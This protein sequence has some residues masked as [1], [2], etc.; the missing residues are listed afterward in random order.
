M[1][2]VRPSLAPH[3]SPTW[4]RRHGLARALVVRTSLAP[5]APIRPQDHL[6]L[7]WMVARHYAR[8]C[9]HSGLE[10]EDLVQEGWFGLCIACER[11]DPGRK[12]KFSTLARWCIR[13]AIVGAIEDQPHP[14]RVPRGVRHAYNRV[15]KGTLDPDTGL[16]AGARD[17]LDAARPF[18]ADPPVQE[19]NAGAGLSFSDLAIDHREPDPATA[20]IDAED[21]LRPPRVPITDDRLRIRDALAALTA[22]ERAV[23]RMECGLDGGESLTHAQVAARLG[24]TRNGCRGIRLRA[25]RR[26]RAMLGVTPP[27]QD[28]QE[29]G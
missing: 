26:L 7:V 3:A 23:I 4:H 20:D 17:C 13:S 2:A 24:F 1:I 19:A 29:G 22:I 25:L 9:P 16:S 21:G 18:L 12:T 5:P 14:V 28:H 27:N 6:G 11:Y 10:V 15:Q 8:A